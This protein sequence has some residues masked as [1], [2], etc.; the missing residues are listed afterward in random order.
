MISRMVYHQCTT[1]DTNFQKVLL[2][3]Y[4]DYYMT[5]C[6][7]MRL[8]ALKKKNGASLT[9]AEQTLLDDIQV[10]PFHLPEPI[11]RQI[12]TIGNVVS[13]PQLP[14]AVLGGFGG[15]YGALVPPAEGVDNTIYNLYEEI[16][17]MAS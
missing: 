6:I 14:V 15:Y 16:P 2:P 9:P 11:L 7:W 10:T 8:T 1:D 17:C 5:A 13:S 12:K 3:E 4:V